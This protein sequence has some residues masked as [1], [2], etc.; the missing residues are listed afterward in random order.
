MGLIAKVEGAEV[1]LGSRASFE[2]CNIKV[3]DNISADMAIY[4]SK[5]H[6]YRCCTFTW[7][8]EGGRGGEKDSNGRKWREGRRRRKRKREDQL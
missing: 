3:L 1:R 2:S 6:R 8:R 4:E 5:G 7:E